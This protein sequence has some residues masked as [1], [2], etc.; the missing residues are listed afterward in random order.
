MWF[1]SKLAHLKLINYFSVR[2][3]WNRNER[4]MHDTAQPKLLIQK[5]IV[6]V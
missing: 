4:V 6:S 5:L 3:V 1:G 2:Q